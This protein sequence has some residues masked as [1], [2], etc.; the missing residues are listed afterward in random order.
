MKKLYYSI[1]EVAEKTGIQQHVLRFWEKE[2][3]MLRPKR[4]KSGNRFYRER[5]VKIVLAIKDLRQN[6]KYTIQGAIE[7]LKEDPSLWETI[8]IDKVK[9]PELDPQPAPENDADLVAE[10]RTKL[11]ELKALVSGVDVKP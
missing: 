5:D 7:R 4:G 11:L 1:R 10:M 9:E 8:S 6:D 3:P 2:F